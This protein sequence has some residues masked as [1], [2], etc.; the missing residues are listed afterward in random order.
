MLSVDITP[1]MSAVGANAK[2]PT[3][4]PPPIHTPSAPQVMEEKLKDMLTEAQ[5]VHDA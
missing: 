2:L 5:R 3:T 4:T 1:L